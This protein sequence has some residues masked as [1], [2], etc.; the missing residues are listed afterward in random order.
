VGL[1]FDSSGTPTVAFTGVGAMPPMETC[2]SND[3]YVTSLQGGTFTTPVQISNGSNAT[4]IAS[5]QKACASE[6]NVC[7]QGDTTGFW[8]AIGFDPS[9]DGLVAFRDIHFGFAMDDFQNSNTDLAIESG[10][11]WQ[12]L[13]IDA[14]R[15]AGEY[16]RI[17]FDP[18]GLAAVLTYNSGRMPGV[19]IE[20]QTKPGGFSTQEAS[21]TWVSQ[22]IFSGNILSQGQLGF[23]INSKGLYAVAYNDASS[24][25]LMYTESMDGTTWSS[26]APV[27]TVG[28]TG[29]Y[30]S[31]AFDGDGNPAIAYYRCNSVGPMQTTCD[32]G[33]DGLLLARRSGTSWNISVVS[34]NSSI[35][36]GLYP[37]LAFV[38]G[39]ATIAFQ[40]V[41]FDPVSMKSSVTWWVAEA[42]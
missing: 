10:G 38:Q 2:G 30:P 42:P 32:P 29:L 14:G 31:L 22:Q 23:G 20:R 41:G 17:A 8:P 33:S 37:A 12:V 39:K 9:N 28:F 25:L 40:E 26:P 7:T 13:G 34:A 24:S 16:N 36:D 15:G 1:A 5:M 21:G 19:Y 6:Q 27:D 3:A 4:I 18:S 11:N 35:Q